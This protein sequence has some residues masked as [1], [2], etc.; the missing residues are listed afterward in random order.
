MKYIMTLF[1]TLSYSVSLLASISNA[2]KNS[3]IKLHQQTAGEQWKVKWDL[4]API[5]TWYGVRI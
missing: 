2:E 5:E 3:L 1:L 4:S